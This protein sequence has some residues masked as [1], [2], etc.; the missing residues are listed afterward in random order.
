MSAILDLAGLTAV[1]VTVRD[2]AVQYHAH[3]GDLFALMYATGCRESESL[4]RDLWRQVASDAW[5]LRPLKGNDPR[6]IQPLFP[7]EGW[8]RWQSG[9]G[10]PFQMLSASRMRATF[11]SLS[12]FPAIRVGAKESACHLFR[13]RYIR[14]LEADGLDVAAIKL[15]MGLRS[16]QVVHRYLTN[17]IVVP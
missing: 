4:R 11:D 3:T 1:C 14:Q 12:P 17:P 6:V 15:R 10:Y 13:Y 9:A 2:R 7:P 5:Q 8:V 16:S